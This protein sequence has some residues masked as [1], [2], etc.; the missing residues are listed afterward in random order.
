MIKKTFHLLCVLVAG[1]LMS[2]LL[3][4]LYQQCFWYFF[5]INLFSPQTYIM[6][7]TFWNNG[8]VLKS[9]DVFLLLGFFSYLPLCLFGWYK[10]NK[11]KYV[12]LILTPLNWLSNLGLNSDGMKEINIKNLKIED[13]KTIDQLVQERIE[14]ENKKSEQLNTSDFR[15][16]IVEQLEKDTN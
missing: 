13:K 6:F 11:Y 2:I 12:N 15:K 4:I 14:M 3:A 10:L 9:G 8:G 5:A 1:L 16:K 7:S